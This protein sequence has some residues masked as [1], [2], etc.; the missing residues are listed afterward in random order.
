M[1]IDANNN[2]LFEEVFMDWCKGVSTQSLAKKIADS[3]DL[4]KDIIISKLVTTLKK[5]GWRP[6]LYYTQGEWGPT[7][8]YA[9]DEDY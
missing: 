1:D 8:H 9:L 6:K 5:L 4:V 2:E 7:T 3:E